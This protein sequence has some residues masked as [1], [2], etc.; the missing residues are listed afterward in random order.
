MIFCG[1]RASHSQVVGATSR[2]RLD[3]SGHAGDRMPPSGAWAC[4]SGRAGTHPWE[5]AGHA[6]LILGHGTSQ[7][8][9]LGAGTLRPSW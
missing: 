2:S 3:H 4:A 9:P 7:T 1:A 5:V 8:A 6:G